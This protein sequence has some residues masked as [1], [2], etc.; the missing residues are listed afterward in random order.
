MKHTSFCEINHSVIPGKRRPAELLRILVP[1]LLLGIFPAEM[2][3]GATIGFTFAIDGGA[4]LTGPPTPATPT[5]G[6]MLFASGTFSPFGNADYTEQGTITFSEYT[7]GAF[8]PSS[9]SNSFTASFNNGADT[10]FGTDVFLFAPPD[11]N[12]QVITNTMTILGGTGM[13]SGATGFANGTGLNTPPP[14]PGALSPVT[15][16]GTGQITAA[17]LQPIPEPGTIALFGAGIVA[18]AAFRR[19]RS[20]ASSL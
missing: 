17:G 18:V 12:G 8:A 14:S 7:S 9:V 15:F 2:I 13:F 5:V 6:V 20:A 19:S 1:S 11:A 10:F 4:A 16:S 3:H